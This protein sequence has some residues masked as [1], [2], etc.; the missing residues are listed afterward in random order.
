MTVLHASFTIERTLAKHS[1]DRVFEAFKNPEKRR[2]WFVEGEGFT[3]HDYTLDF[4]VGARE[5]GSFSFGDGPTVTNDTYYLDIVEPQRLVFAY[6]MTVGGKPLSS[7]LTTIQFEKHGAGTKLTYTEQGAFIDG[8]PDD[9]KNREAGTGE[10]L[11]ALEK[12]LNR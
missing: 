10:L 4:R 3:I 1:V 5:G 12:E 7:S 6:A 9:V 11:G 2:R 8:T